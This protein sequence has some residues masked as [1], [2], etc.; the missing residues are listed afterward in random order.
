M[1]ANIKQPEQKGDT[2]LDP[3][4]KPTSPNKRRKQLH[5]HMYTHIFTH[6]YTHI[7]IH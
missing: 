3:I 2:I 4:E 5:T 7:H 1:K 6:I